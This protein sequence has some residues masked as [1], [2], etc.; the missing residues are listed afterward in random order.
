MNGKIRVHLLPEAGTE[1]KPKRKAV[2]YQESNPTPGPSAY[3]PIAPWLPPASASTQR[4]RQV[5]PKPAFTPSGDNIPV[6]VSPTNIRAADSQVPQAHQP[7]EGPGV[8]PHNVTGDTSTLGKAD[9]NSSPGTSIQDAN[10]QAVFASASN[11]NI[12]MGN[13]GASHNHVG[14]ISPHAPILWGYCF[15]CDDLW[16]THRESMMGLLRWQGAGNGLDSNPVTCNIFSSYFAFQDHAE[17][18]HGWRLGG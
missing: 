7:P 11:A 4:F 6:D 8:T 2:R 5:L 9:P 13:Q 1:Q 15:I 10:V 12:V 18:Y 16:R 3:P 14:Q 17:R